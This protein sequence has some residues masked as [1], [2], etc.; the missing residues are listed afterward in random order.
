MPYTRKDN[1]QQVDNLLGC[2][3]AAGMIPSAQ[4][5]TC[6][7]ALSWLHIK[8]GANCSWVHA[9]MWIAWEDMTRGWENIIAEVK[10]P[11][12]DLNFMYYINYGDFPSAVGA[13]SEISS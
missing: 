8:M 3:V 12:E 1:L 7:L 6:T 2:T 13:G 4:D 5:Q 11:Q 10:S 9:I